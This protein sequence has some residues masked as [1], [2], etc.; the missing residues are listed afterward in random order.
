M[1]NLGPKDW[2]HMRRRLQHGRDSEWGEVG[3]VLCQGVRPFK[4]EIYWERT[5]HPAVGGGFLVRVGPNGGSMS[6][7]LTELEP[8][9]VDN[10]PME[11]LIATRL[12]RDNFELPWAIYMQARTG[13]ETPGN[14]KRLWNDQR[15]KKTSWART[16]WARSKFGLWYAAVGVV[17]MLHTDNKQQI[18]K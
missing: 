5:S 8:D 4:K 1:Q 2:Y 10:P 6:A 7:T 13:H 18:R 11:S 12:Q 16:L 17:K 9:P 14:I 15:T 3:K